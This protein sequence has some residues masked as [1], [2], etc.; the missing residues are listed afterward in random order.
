[1]VW[2]SIGPKKWSFLREFRIHS[3]CD[4]NSREGPAA[5][6]GIESRVTLIEIYIEEVG[7]FLQ[8]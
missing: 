1:M 2:D 4:L 7:L 8:K 5:R 3:K 6:R